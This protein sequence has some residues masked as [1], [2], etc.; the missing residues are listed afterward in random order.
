MKW[1]IF[2]RVIDNHGDIGVCWRLAADLAGRGEQVRLWVDDPSALQWLAPAGAPGVS[3]QAWGPNTRWPVPGE[4]LV[5]AFGCEPA[6]DFVAAYAERVRANGSF[7]SWI[8]LEYLSAE[9][10]VARSHGLP[11]PVLSGPGQGLTKHFFY[12]GFTLQTGGLLREPGLA[13]RQAAFDRRSWLTSRGIADQGER[14]ISLFCYEPPALDAL[15]AQLGG[16]PEPTH[17]LVTA[18]RAEAAVRSAMTRHTRLPRITFL[19][20]LAQAQFD[21]LL[22][23]CDFNFVRGEDSLVRAIWAGKPFAWQLYPQHDAAHHHK[24]AA[25]VQLLAP[26]AEWARFLHVWNGAQGTALPALQARQWLSAAAGF[27][28]QLLAQPDLTSALLGFAEKTR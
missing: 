19:P 17:L 11:S 22:W 24:L 14:L 5:E 16:A 4:V 21:E 23:A 9:P 10:F 2:C 1:D 15:L 28:A 8:N 18:G 25:F 26:P 20:L 3:V 12:P 13:H 27:Q 6:I 7:Y